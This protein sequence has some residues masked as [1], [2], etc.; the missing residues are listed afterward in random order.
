MFQKGQIRYWGLNKVDEGLLDALIAD[1]SFKSKRK[2]L[3]KVSK[4]KPP[5]KVSKKNDSVDKILDEYNKTDTIKPTKTV[6]SKPKPQKTTKT[7]DEK[8]K[9]KLNEE[10]TKY[11]NSNLDEMKF[12]EFILKKGIYS[13]IEI[14]KPDYSGGFDD[15]DNDDEDNYG[16]VL[17][18]NP[19]VKKTVKYLYDYYKNIK[20]FVKSYL[21]KKSGN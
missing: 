18:T 7:M 8:F 19:D 9:G 16:N 2:P 17:Y 14:Y 15:Y 3:P 12:D 1:R 11:A 6:I 10:I 20:F 21:K 4:R 5:S 13:D